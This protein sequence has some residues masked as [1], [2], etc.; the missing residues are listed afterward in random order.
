MSYR[1]NVCRAINVLVPLNYTFCNRLGSKNGKE[2]IQVLNR[3]LSLI[4]SRGFHID[5]IVTDAESVVQYIAD[6]LKRSGISITIL[7]QGESAVNCESK[8]RIKKRTRAIIHT[9]PYR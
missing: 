2:I 8:I 5:D 7:S 3:Q 1:P 4:K 6:E 9:P